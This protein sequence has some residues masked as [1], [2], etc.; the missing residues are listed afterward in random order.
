MLSFTTTQ[1]EVIERVVALETRRVEVDEAAAVYK[2]ALEVRWAL[3][4]VICIRL[5]L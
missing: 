3:S 4:R 1:Q 5:L 2:A